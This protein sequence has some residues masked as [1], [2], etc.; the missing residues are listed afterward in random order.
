MAE[1]YS[2]PFWGVHRV[3][4]QR[5]LAT[6]CKELRVEIRLASRVV[7]VSFDT[8]EIEVHG[9]EREQG[10]VVI[11]AE[12]LWSVTHSRFLGHVSEPMST[13]DMAYRIAVDTTKLPGP[14]GD[15][16]REFAREAGVNLWVGPHSHAVTYSVR[17]GD[18]LGLGILRPDDLPVDTV[19]TTAPHVEVADL[20][21]DWDPLLRKILEGAGTVLKW[22]LLYVEALPEWGSPS[23]TFF[24]VGDACHP[25]LPYLAQGANS[26]LED[27]AVLGVLLGKV[28]REGKAAQL[29]RVAR[30]YQSL[31]RD[32]GAEIQKESH[33]PSARR[34]TSQTGR[35][36]SRGTRPCWLRLGGSRGRDSLR[37]GLVRRSRG[38]CTG[39]MLTP[40][41]RGRM[42][43][44]TS[45]VDARVL[46][47]FYVYSWVSF[48][49]QVS[50]M[51]TAPCCSVCPEQ[52]ITCFD[53]PSYPG[54]MRCGSS[55]V[56]CPIPPA[57][58]IPTP[59]EC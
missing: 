19:K 43:R 27:G 40:R 29:R 5:A 52:P 1:R 47:S 32:R 45:R 23:S 31:R 13:G 42:L 35:L 55:P 26:T 15:E 22:K 2:F 49:A 33:L 21:S 25:M 11:C 48:N 20:L 51:P 39:M 3:D 4:L 16:M 56:S 38:S 53:I 54:D 50:Y 58:H 7:D 34:S 9:G 14:Y 57:I 17:G 59:F 28:R 8:A 6:R 36:R 37:G 44:T 41:R 18:F 10:D 24:M 46:N 12:G 30:I